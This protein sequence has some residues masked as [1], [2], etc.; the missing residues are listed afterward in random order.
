MF[1]VCPKCTLTLALT[2]N[3]LRVGQGYVRCGRCSNVFNALLKLSEAPPDADAGTPPIAQADP[4]SRSQITRAISSAASDTAQ[5]AAAPAPASAP[6]LRP[7]ARAHPH[8]LR[9][10]PRGPRPPRVLC[11]RRGLRIRRRP[12]G[13]R[14]R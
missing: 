11:G 1:T 5:T 7:A 3:D 12:Q 9:P 8:P 14:I 6:R 4:A 13:L 2:A 10:T